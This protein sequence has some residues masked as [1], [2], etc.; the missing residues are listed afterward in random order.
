VNVRIRDISQRA[1]IARAAESL[2]SSV[3]PHV[4]GNKLRRLERKRHLR[5]TTSLGGY[6]GL[7]RT[8]SSSA[9]RYGDQWMDAV[10][11]QIVKD[12]DD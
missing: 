4:Q 6:P 10:W 3:Y 2:Y 11:E 9:E 1:E 7:L 12:A 5:R 8:R